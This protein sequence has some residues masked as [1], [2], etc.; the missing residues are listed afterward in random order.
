MSVEP[1]QQ[2]AE[3]GVRLE[4]LLSPATL[5]EKRS[6]VLI[7]GPALSGKLDVGL[8]LLAAVAQDGDAISVS[9]TDPADQVQAEYD[10]AGG[11]VDALSVVDATAGVTNRSEEVYSVSTPGDL[12]GIGIA[13]AQAT[14]AVEDPAPPVLIDSLSALLMYNDAETVYQFAESVRTQTRGGAGVTISTLNTD[15]LDD[16]DRNRLLGLASVVVETRITEDG[17]REFQVRDDERT[18]EWHSRTG[19]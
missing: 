18:G 13:I 4:T 2:T 1:G 17:R 15:A 19:T 6:H 3:S 8:E 5:R 7:V 12:T 9:T 10:A 16:P 14:D 11:A